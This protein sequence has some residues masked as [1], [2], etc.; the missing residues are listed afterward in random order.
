MVPPPDLQDEFQDSK[1]TTL[2]I[3]VLQEFY[4]MILKNMGFM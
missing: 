4:D 2:Q 1:K 3:T